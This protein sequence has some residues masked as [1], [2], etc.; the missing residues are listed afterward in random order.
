MK[1]GRVFFASGWVGKSVLVGREGAPFLPL[2][3]LLTGLLVHGI[4]RRGAFDNA[5]VD[6]TETNITETTVLHTGIPSIVVRDKE[7]VI[8]RVFDQSGMFSVLCFEHSLG[9][10]DSKVLVATAYTVPRAVVRA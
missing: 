3:V 8:V 4:E 7:V 6:T 5:A 1:T 10:V 2:A 9:V